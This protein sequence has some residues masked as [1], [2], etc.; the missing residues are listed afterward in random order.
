MIYHL[1]LGAPFLEALGTA[2]AAAVAVFLSWA[3]GREI[4]PAYEWSAFAA[5]PLSFAA[6]LIYGSPALAVLFFI[7]LLGRL[8]NGTSGLQATVF[9]ALMLIVLGAVLFTGGTLLALP[10]LAAAFG[11]VGV[12][13]AP[14]ASGRRYGLYALISLVLFIVMI[15]FFYPQHYYVPGFSIYTGAAAL[16]LAILTVVLVVRAGK[17]LVSGD[18]NEEPLDIR[19]IRLAQLMLALFMIADIFF[20]GG[21][22]LV[23]LYPALFAY[24]GTAASNLVRRPDH[25]G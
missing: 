24:L 1:V 23:M 21:I 2:G 15:I 12:L 20:K 17:G 19:R 7:L 18:N 25:V 6:F 10:F 8:I 16:A 22:A 13:F 5:L 9:D 14:P 11:L 3:I 4:D